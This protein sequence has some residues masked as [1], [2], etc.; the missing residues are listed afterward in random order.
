M[1]VGMVVPSKGFVGGIER[2]A[3]DLAGSL[4]ARGHQV[5]LLHGDAEGRD[6]ERYARPFARV[7]PVGE[8]GRVRRTLDVVWVHRA[9]HPNELVPFAGLPLLVSTHDHDLTCVRSHRYLFDLTPC[10]R[11]PG[12]ACVTHGCVAVRD[13]RPEARLPIALR[14]PFRLRARLHA[15]AEMAPLV[16]CSRYV[17][18]NVIAA[19][20]P[21]ERVQVL[22]PIPPEDGAAPAPPPRSRRLGV[23]GNLLRGKGVDI[24]IEALRWLA[25]DVTLEVVGDGPSRESLERLGRKL[26]PGRVRFHGWVPPSRLG[27]IYEDLAAVVVPSRWPEPFGMT[28]IEAMRRGRAVIGAAHGGI[29]EWLHPSRAGRLFRPGSPEDLARAAHEVLGD[30]AAGALA[31]EWASE[32]FPHR[33]LVDEAEALLDAVARGRAKRTTARTHIAVEGLR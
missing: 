9:D 18:D 19:G 21:A 11:P 17:A 4:R 13:R 23:V 25:Q 16:A 24:A 12:A 26:A 32:R 14:S 28:G 33:R 7:L 2:H 5:I 3:H 22:H 30:P 1:R 20:V 10:H 8:V 27:A 15:I 6:P 29:P 31:F